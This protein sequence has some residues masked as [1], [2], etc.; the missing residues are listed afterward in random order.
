[1]SQGL[2]QNQI[3]ESDKIFSHQEK[4]IADLLASEGKTV[5]SLLET[6]Q[7]RTADAEV[8]GIPTEFKSLVIGATNSTVKNLINSSIRRGQARK[9]IIDARG[10][11]LTE[12]EANLG[13]QRAKNISRGKIDSVRIIGDGYDLISNDFQ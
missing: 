11:G 10:S 3:D 13:L 2:N 4:A 7:G 1:M 9:I 8:D 6:N 5:K 12:A